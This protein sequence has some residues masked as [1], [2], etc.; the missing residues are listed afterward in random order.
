MNRKLKEIEMTVAKTSETLL[1]NTT[2]KRKATRGKIVK[3]PSAMKAIAATIVDKGMRR[4][5]LNMCL[6]AIQTDKENRDG[7]RSRR[8]EKDQTGTHRE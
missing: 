2:D 3:L 6:D 7:A 1:L 8:N 5:Y 4:Q